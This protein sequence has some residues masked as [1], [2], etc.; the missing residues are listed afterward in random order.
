MFLKRK[1][2]LNIKMFKIQNKTFS[3][4]TTINGCNIDVQ[5]VTVK[6]GAKLTLDAE[7]ETTIN[8]P[9]EVETGAELE[10]K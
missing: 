10:I 2:Y 1:S 5:N 6:N 7:K 3:N 8:G 4:N 9:F